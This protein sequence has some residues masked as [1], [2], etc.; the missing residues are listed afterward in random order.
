MGVDVG[1]VGGAFLA[2]VALAGAALGFGGRYWLAFEPRAAGIQAGRTRVLAAVITA[3]LVVAAVWR[4]GATMD[5]LAYAFFIAVGVQLS[6]IDLK[7]RVLPNRIVLPAAVIGLVLLS[8]AALT[9]GDADD[10]IRA[11]LGALAL[12][13]V[14]LLLAVVSPSGLGM[15][16]VKLALVVGLFLAYLGWT[17]L[18]LGTLAAFVIASVV[19]LLLIAARRANRHSAIPFGPFMVV[20]ALAVVISGQALT[21]LVVPSL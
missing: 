7:H 13:G 6:I 11:V 10:L 4:F 16:D 8:L 5:A 18:F 3:G 15:G 9:S 20:G 14:Y 17:A 12:F 19:A 1:L 21:D 2:A